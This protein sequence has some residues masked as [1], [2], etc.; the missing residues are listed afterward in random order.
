MVNRI[1]HWLTMRIQLWV[2]HEIHKKERKCKFIQ[3]LHVP[4]AAQLCSHAAELQHQPISL[5]HKLCMISTLIIIITH[6]HVQGSCAECND[7]LRYC[8]SLVAWMFLE[9]FEMKWRRIKAAAGLCW[10]KFAK[11]PNVSTQ[12]WRNHWT[13]KEEGKE[14]SKILFFLSHFYD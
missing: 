11:P 5:N 7:V 10:T 13:F 12:Y 14:I 9:C 3:A 6:Y 1:F 8:L 2:D 4:E